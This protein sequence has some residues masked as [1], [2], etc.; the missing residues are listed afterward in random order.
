MTSKIR[1]YRTVVVPPK[2]HPQSCRAVLEPWIGFA[3]KRHALAWS[4]SRHTPASVAKRLNDGGSQGLGFLQTFLGSLASMTQLYPYL[5]ELLSFLPPL[6]LHSGIDSVCLFSLLLFGPQPRV[7]LPFRY[8]VLSVRFLHLCMLHLAGASQPSC[9]CYFFLRILTIYI[10]MYVF[11][12]IFHFYF[13]SFFGY[14]FLFKAL[15]SQKCHVVFSGV[16]YSSTAFVRLS[17]PQGECCAISRVS[18]CVPD[19]TP[20]GASPS[21]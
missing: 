6:L 7:T 3:C 4:L 20:L 12:S 2:S 10:L 16:P 5:A 19:S 21:I 17:D 11:F 1:P 13:W 14:F 8:L 18:D 9:F 15:W